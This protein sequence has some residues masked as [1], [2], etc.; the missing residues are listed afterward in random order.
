MVNI[1]I[2]IFVVVVVSEYHFSSI[3]FLRL[4]WGKCFFLFFFWPGQHELDQQQGLRNEKET[5][6][7]HQIVGIDVT[8]R[9][10]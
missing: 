6:P 1:I 3:S 9:G 4:Q 7:W 5:L 10:R 8:T 2:T